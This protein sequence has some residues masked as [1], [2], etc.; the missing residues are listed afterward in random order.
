MARGTGS[1]EGERAQLGLVGRLALD[2]LEA[3][4]VDDGTEERRAQLGNALE[5]RLVLLPEHAVEV[6]EGLRARASAQ[7]KGGGRWGEKGPYRCDSGPDSEI[8]LVLE[9]GDKGEEAS[10]RRVA[11]TRESVRVRDKPDTILDGEGRVLLR[12]LL[13]EELEVRRRVGDT[14]DSDGAY[15]TTRSKSAPDISTTTTGES[16]P[17]LSLY[18]LEP[19]RSMVVSR[20]FRKAFASM[21]FSPLAETVRS[22]RGVCLRRGPQLY[23]FRRN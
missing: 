14:V 10:G 17:A 23:T 22:C 3:E 16:A 1:A 11:S 4:A 2:G 9:V 12:G 15:E 19:L 8:V 13:S 20:S 18:S 5:G 7:R 6:G 21:D